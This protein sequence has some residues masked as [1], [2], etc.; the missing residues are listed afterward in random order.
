MRLAR[1]VAAGLVAGVVAGFVA[2]LLRPR[3][4]GSHPQAAAVPGAGGVQPPPAEPTSGPGPELDL[5][6]VEEARSTTPTTPP[7]PPTAELG[8]PSGSLADP[9]RPPT[10]TAFRSSMPALGPAVTTPGV[11]PAPASGPLAGRSGPVV[12]GLRSSWSVTG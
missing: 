4:S 5:R 1:L 12:L 9:L 2:A 11:R 7:H 10:G 8:R 3:R 6:S